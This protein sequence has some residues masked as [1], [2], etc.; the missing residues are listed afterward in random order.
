MDLI[1][2]MIGGFAVALQPVN[3]LAALV[4]AL[5]GTAT[6]VLPGLG[7]LGA[8]AILMPIT[9]HFSA[10]TGLIMLA[11]IYYGAMYGG[12]TTAILLKIPGEGGSIVTTIDGYEFAKK[13]RAGAALM[14]CAVG[15]FIAGTISI[16]GLSLFTPVLADVALRFSSPEFCMLALLGAVTL[17]RITGRDPMRNML[18]LLMGAALATIGVDAVSGDTRFTFERESLGL[19]FD[20][21]PIT[22]GLYGLSELFQVVASTQGFPRAETVRLRDM[23][24]TRAEWSRAW[25][26]IVRGS[27]IGFLIGLLPGPGSLTSTFASYG[28]ERGIARRHRDEFGKGAVEGFAGPEAANN[29]VATSALVPVLSLGIPFTPNVALLLGALI[30]QGIQPGPLLLAQHPD[31]VWGLLASMCI[32][33]IALLALNLPLVGI[34]VR[35]L[36]VPQYALIGGIFVISF[37][38][39]YTMRSSYWDLCVLLG[40]GIIGFVLRRMEF[41]MAPLVLGLVMGPIFEK[42]LRETLFLSGGNLTIF[43]TRPISATLVALCVVALLA[44]SALNWINRRR[45]HVPL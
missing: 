15:S 14:I 11:G 43:V 17:I 20:L 16:L 30:V 3:L 6:G 2:G 40:A 26:A 21:V 1:N 41:D 12:S 38:G 24:P 39:V 32:G 27:G 18:M 13:G 34:W 22:L 8:M 9:I 23:V 4:G 28:V 42:A 29:A 37:I 33:N 36:R 44:P 19:G 45:V 7:V 25:P 35:L 31:V 5:V 10:V